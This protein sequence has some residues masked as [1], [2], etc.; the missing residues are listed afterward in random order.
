M[1]RRAAIAGIIVAGLLAPLSTAVPAGADSHLGCA[2]N[3]CSIL[4]SKLI[5]LNGDAGTGSGFLPIS[6]DPPPC[7]W[8]PIGN[9]VT[10]SR[11]L[12]RQWGLATPGT[13]FGVFASVQ[14][15]KH[16]LRTRAAPTAGTWYMLPVNPAASAAGQRA[17][18]R[19]PLFFFAR[20]GQ[21]PPAPPIPPRTLA[22]F[23]Y[24][25]M[26]IPRPALTTN[27]AARGYVNLGTYVW[28]DWP[29]SRTTGRMI[30]YKITATLGNRTVTVWARASGFAVNVAGPGTPYSRGCGPTGSRY[31]VG[32]PPAG[33]GP[34]TPPDC[35]VLWQAPSTG[36]ALTATVRWLV[37]WGVGDL[38]GPGNNALP[39][40]LTTGPVPP[41]RVPVGE[42]QSVNSG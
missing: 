7:L 31:P 26:L 36:A 22:E 27:P 4:L 37:T 14:Q 17:C 30:A 42:I 20:R 38:D 16:L 3:D 18:R 25:H 9:A 28:G 11:Y 24:N 8:E 19:E 29:A 39:P 40:I 10:G 13:A 15:A 23:A 2:G 6:L 34:G 12:V 5:S 33:A 21:T 35:G 1:I 41:F 32:R